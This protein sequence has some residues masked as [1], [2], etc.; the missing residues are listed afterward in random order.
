LDVLDF[1][2]LVTSITNSNM[3]RHKYMQVPL[4]NYLDAEELDD[5]DDTK[6]KVDLI[7]HDA[8]FNSIK[9]KLA[10]SEYKMKYSP[11]FVNF[12]EVTGFHFLNRIKQVTSES[13]LPKLDENNYINEAYDYYISINNASFDNID[14]GGVASLFE[15]KVS[16]VKG[17]DFKIHG[18]D[19]KDRAYQDKLKVGLVSMHIPDEVLTHKYMRKPKVTPDRVARLRKVLD[20]AEQEDVDLLVFPEISIPVS[21][22]FWIAEYARNKQRA[23]IFG[24]E[25]WIVGNQALNLVVTLLPLKVNGYSSLVMNLRLKNHYSPEEDSV[26]KSYKYDIPKNEKTYYDLITWK[27]VK[28]TVFNCYELCNVEHRS[29]FRSKVDVLFASEFNKDISHFSNIVES[30]SRDLHCYV[31]QSNDS[32]FGDSRIAQPASTVYKDLLK[33]KGGVNPF[34][35]AGELDLASLREFQVKDYHGQKAHKYFKPTPPD[36]DYKEVKK[37]IRD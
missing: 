36:F 14:D 4:L 10:L 32:R 2:S 23:M 31:V 13:V 25:H 35:I 3:A 22:L 30:T 16:G 24:L 33:L 9:S 26:L 8:Y 34:V 1:E 5:E 37:R 6:V 20:H 19:I 11:R 28:F 17:K 12:D 29:H 21:S 18:L 7:H 15:S 27:G